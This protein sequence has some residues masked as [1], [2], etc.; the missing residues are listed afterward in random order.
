MLLRY[1]SLSMFLVFAGCATSVDQA[2]MPDRNTAN[3][4][5]NIK[6]SLSNIDDSSKFFAAKTQLSEVERA[7]KQNDLARAKV[8]LE[9]MVP[10]QSLVI[11]YLFLSAQTAIA[12]RQ[13][14]AALSFLSDE[15][16]VKSKMDSVQAIKFAKLKSNAYLLN[17]SFIASAKELINI[18]SLLERNERVENHENIYELLMALPSRSLAIQADKEIN[19][20]TRGWLSLAALTKQNENDPAY[21]RSGRTGYKKMSDDFEK[22]IAFSAACDLVFKGRVQPSGYTEPLLHQKRLEVKKSN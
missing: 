13:S 16:L 3:S 9:L 2:D 12:D 20:P 1:L 15:R 11:E 7:L 4:K 21:G 18:D 19:G 22:S 14:N 10:P 5:R 6:S 8:V 17:R